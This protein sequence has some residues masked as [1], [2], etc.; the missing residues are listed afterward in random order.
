MDGTSIVLSLGSSIA[1]VVSALTAIHWRFSNK[2]D[3]ISNEVDKKMDELK[4]EITLLKEEVTSLKTDIRWI[5]KLLEVN[6]NDKKE[7]R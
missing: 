2:V 3:K 4:K 5:K 1:T 6:N 7:N